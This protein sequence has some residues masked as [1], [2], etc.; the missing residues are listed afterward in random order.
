MATASAPA[1]TMATGA[2]LRGVSEV[3][4]ARGEYQRPYQRYGGGGFHGGRGAGC[5]GDF[6]GRAEAMGISSHVLCHL[7]TQWESQDLCINMSRDMTHHRTPSNRNSGH[8]QQ[9][10]VRTLVPTWKPV[11]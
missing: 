11:T 2:M 8:L 5:Q 9:P 4:L 1:T 6:C 10:G 7:G 3:H